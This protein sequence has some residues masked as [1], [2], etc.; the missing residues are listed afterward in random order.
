MQELLRRAWET[1]DGGDWERRICRGSLVSKTQYRHV[2]DHLGFE[3]ARDET[4]A[5]PRTEPGAATHGEWTD[6]AAVSPGSGG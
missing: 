3:D 2:L 6:D 5:P 4:A 1:I